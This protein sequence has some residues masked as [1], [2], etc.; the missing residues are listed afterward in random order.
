MIPKISNP[1]RVFI[2]S[3]DYLMECIYKILANVLD[4]LLRLVIGDFI[5]E[6]YSIFEKNRKI[7]DDII[8]ANN[9]DGAKRKNRIHYF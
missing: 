3:N 9:M 6:A 5:S 1:Y 4:K 8:V 2:F 7:L